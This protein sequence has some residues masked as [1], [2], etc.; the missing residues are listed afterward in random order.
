M[1][2]VWTYVHFHP[3]TDGAGD[4]LE[5][6]WVLLHVRIRAAFGEARRLN[7]KQ[8]YLRVVLWRSVH[9]EGS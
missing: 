1:S 4:Q 5:A 9:C 7:I 3:L 2:S 6:V 8:C